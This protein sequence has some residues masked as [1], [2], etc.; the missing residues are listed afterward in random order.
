LK[1]VKKQISLFSDPSC[2]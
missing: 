1:L 2:K